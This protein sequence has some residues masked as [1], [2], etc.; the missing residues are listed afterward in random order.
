MTKNIIEVDPDKFPWLDLNR[1]TFCMGVENAGILYLSGQTASEYD[2]E[3]GKVVCKGNI[4][5]QTRT[6]YEKLSVV[7]EAAGMSFENVVQ[8][9]DYIDATGLPLYRQTGSIRA[10]FLKGTPLGATGICVE[11][12]LRPDA[13]IEVSM[14]AMKGE[15]K[16]INPGWDRYGQLTYVPGVEVEGIVWSSGFVGSEDI[17]G[18]SD[19]PQDTVRQAELTYGIISDVLA[20]A[21]AL[22]KD[23]VRT[24]DY[25]SP[26]CL[27]QY[28]KTSDVRRSFFGG[29]FPASTNIPVNRLLRPDGHV[30][31]EI[32]AVKDGIREELRIPEWEQNYDGLTQ[33]AGVRKGRLLQISGQSSVDYVTGSTVGGYDIVS[34]TDQAYS[35]ISRIMDEAGFSMDNIVN[36]I[37]WVA[38][39]GMMDYR[40]VGEVRRKYF[41]DRFP[42]ATGVSIHQILGRPEQLIEVTAVAVV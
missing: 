5:D 9:V 23:V 25:I 40:K 27:L 42:S 13:F 39:N 21:G 37:E 29:R 18:Q 30:E 11:R 24:L 15:K 4:L 35:N 36:T 7:L 14:V 12:L 22:P 2:P 33:N 3:L 34:Q 17:N 10:E 8:T 6:I 38:P 28:P 41:G 1:Y 20:G 31:I 32:V 26:Q 16:P 19:Y